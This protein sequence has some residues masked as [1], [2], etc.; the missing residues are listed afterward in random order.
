MTMTT[1]RRRFSACR[2][3]EKLSCFSALPENSS[4]SCA[5]IIYTAFRLS[6]VALSAHKLLFAVCWFALVI[7]QFINIPRS[8]Y[9]G[10]SCIHFAGP[11]AEVFSLLFRFQNRLFSSRT[12]S[13]LIEGVFRGK[14]RRKSRATSR[15]S[16]ALRDE[17]WKDST[18]PLISEFFM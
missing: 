18:N 4:A 14:L 12:Q 5:W 10:K 16:L 13:T 9:N 2:W 17:W 1:F 6:I 7:M 3:H 8:R 15:F 11:S